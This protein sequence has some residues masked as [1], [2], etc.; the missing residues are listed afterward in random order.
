MGHHLH[1]NNIESATGIATSSSASSQ[2]TTT[3]SSSQCSLSGTGSTLKIIKNVPNCSQQKLSYTEVSYSGA[4]ASMAPIIT[5]AIDIQRNGSETAH[6]GTN[7]V[8]G[9]AVPPATTSTTST[10]SAASSSSNAPQQTIPTISSTNTNKGYRPDNALSIFGTKL[11][12]YEHTEVFFY[13][14]NF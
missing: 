9:I 12:S 8:S 5:S 11:T 4:P 6:N 1:N 10:S 13:K 3:T 7:F 14:L 2:S